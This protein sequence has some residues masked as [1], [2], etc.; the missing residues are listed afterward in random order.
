MKKPMTEDQLYQLLCEYFDTFDTDHD[1]Y[2]T[3]SDVLT[4]LGSIQ[5]HANQKRKKKLRMDCDE[6]RIL[7]RKMDV[8]GDGRISKE[9]FYRFY[10]SNR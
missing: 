4:M 3:F 8:S 7:F 6:M 1:D 10:K 9:E 5:T 2:L